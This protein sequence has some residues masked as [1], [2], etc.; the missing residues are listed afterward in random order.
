MEGGMK[1]GVTVSVAIATYSRAG[2][3]RQAI[4]AALAQTRPPDEIVV[5]DDASADSTWAALEELAGRESSLRI[6]RRERNSGGAENWSFAIG[7]TRGDYI[8]WCSDD[9]RFTP[10]HLEASVEYLEANPEVGL[11][12]SGFVDAIETQ[13]A[14]KTI[15]RPLRFAR[16][17]IITTGDLLGYLTR[18]YDWPFHPSTLV[19]RRA[20][21][22]RVGGFDPA[23]ALADTDWFVRAV[24]RFPAAMLPRHGVYNRRHAGNWSNRLGSARMQREIFEIVERSIERRFPKMTPRRLIWKAVWRAVWRTNVRLRLLL[25]LRAR[26]RSGHADAACAAWSV[27]ARGTGRT[28]PEF[29]THAG[30]RVIRWWCGRRVPEFEDG[31]QSVSPL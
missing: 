24:E 20:V 30:S 4:E 6:F 22:E 14:P 18:Y 8:A 15:P 9:D 1:G 31:R 25:T 27:L 11:V 5:A 2:M 17:R 13:G 21:W 16:T 10:S 3:V 7:Q 28:L 29:I 12:H 23:Y 26:L 19:L